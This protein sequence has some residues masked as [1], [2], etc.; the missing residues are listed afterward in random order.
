MINHMTAKELAA[1]IGGREYGSEMSVKECDA[2]CADGL[3]VVLGA[4]DDLIEFNG[5][6]QDEQD[7]YNG[8]KFRLTKDGLLQYPEYHCAQ[9][10]CPYIKEASTKAKE[11][12]AVWHDEGNPCWTYETDIPHETFKIMGDGEVYCEGIVFSV[13][14]L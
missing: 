8:G 13:E 9:V 3:V 11:I 6:I 2:A 10:N 4:S 7:A 1:L 12:R 5:A 14:D